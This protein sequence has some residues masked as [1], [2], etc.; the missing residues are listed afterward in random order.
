MPHTGP[1]VTAAAVTLSLETAAGLD[2]EPGDLAGYGPITADQAR[3]LAALARSWLPVLTDGHGRAVAAARTLRIPPAWLQRLVRLR[4]RHCRF[5]G[6]RRAA[7]QCEIDHIIAWEDCGET[8]LENLQCLCKAHHRAKHHG[9]WKTR[10]GPEGCIYWTSHTGHRYDT[11]PDD[12]WAITLP[13]AARRAGA[14][15]DSGPESGAGTSGPSA[16]PGAAERS[17]GPG[18]DPGG[19]EPPPF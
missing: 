7:A 13:P 16:G 3:N 17:A 14:E 12:R 15:P 6:C 18:Q 5:P 4:D 19:K 1:A 2:N 8:T 10:P 11:E 9:G